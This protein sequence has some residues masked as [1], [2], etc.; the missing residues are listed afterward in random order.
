MRTSDRR[1]LENF[2]ILSFVSCHGVQTLLTPRIEQSSPSAGFGAN[3]VAYAIVLSTGIDDNGFLEFPGNLGDVSACS[4]G[5]LGHCL[6]VGFASRAQFAEKLKCIHG[7]SYS[8][9]AWSDDCCQASDFASHDQHQ[10]DCEPSEG[11]SDGVG[12]CVSDRDKVHDSN[13]HDYSAARR[14][15]L[16]VFDTESLVLSE[17]QVGSSVCLVGSSSSSSSPCFRPLGPGLLPPVS[18]G[19]GCSVGCAS[20]SNQG[21]RPRLLPVSSGLAP[22][23]HCLSDSSCSREGSSSVVAPCIRPSH[24]SSSL[25]FVRRLRGGG[26]AGASDE[27]SGAELDSFSSDGHYGG[28]QCAACDP[29]GDS[30]GAIGSGVCRVCDQSPGSESVKVGSMR[31]SGGPCGREMLSSGVDASVVPPVPTKEED[32]SSLVAGRDLR[33]LQCPYFRCGHRRAIEGLVITLVCLVVLVL[34]Q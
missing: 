9:R 33:Y 27:D 20:A 21:R 25:H 22:S 10:G 2:L 30:V 28:A 11:S 1:R 6:P 17:Y 13:Q 4:I 12:D 14:N 3:K 29:W 7:L 32:G 15:R 23:A 34:L 8:A 19:L 18:Y 31:A 5:Y 24:L 16:P 26:S